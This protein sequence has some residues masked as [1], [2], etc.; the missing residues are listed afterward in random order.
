MSLRTKLEL[1]CLCLQEKS[2]YKAAFNQLRDLKGEIEQLQLLLEQSRQRLQRDF[3]QWCT[4]MASQQ[5]EQEQSEEQRTSKGALGIGQQKHLPTEHD[6]HPFHSKAGGQQA[7]AAAQREGQ[8]DTSR[9]DTHS[10]KGTA[11]KSSS[12]LLATDRIGDLCLADVDQ[13]VMEAARPHLTG[14]PTADEDIIKFYEARA[15]LLQKLG[16]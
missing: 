10:T 1:A 7:A 8:R 4:M 15:K 2:S 5:Q 9:E 3:Q 6:R 12:R 14:N 11:V 13:A 16:R